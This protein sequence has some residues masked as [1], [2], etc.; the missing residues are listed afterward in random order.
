MH[1]YLQEHIKEEING[2]VDYMTKAVEHKKDQ[3]GCMFR[4]MAEAELEHANAL[5]KIFLTTEKSKEMTDA[6]YSEAVTA[7]M[8][9]YNTGMGKYEALKK[10]YWEV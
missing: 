5:S 2:A 6:E 7:V 8:N 4:K 3:M 10:L 9:Y 1:K